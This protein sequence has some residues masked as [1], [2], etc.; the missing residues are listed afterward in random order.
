M[1]TENK[2]AS[3]R[4]RGTQKLRGG[5]LPTRMPA[6]F[7]STEV[8]NRLE[9]AIFNLLSS[10][11]EADRFW[12]KKQNCRVFNKK[13]YYSEARKSN[14]VFDVS[15]EVYL[16]GASTYSVLVL[17]ECKNYSS[18]PVPVDDV[19]E[20]YAKTQQVTG[21]NVKAIVATSTA[22]QTGALEF[23]KSKRIGLLRY[24]GSENFKWELYRSPSA[25]SRGAQPNVT[26]EITSGLT[27]P[28]FRSKVFDLFIQSPARATNS[29]WEF[30]DDVFAGAELSAAQVRKLANPKS[31][32]ANTVPFRE[33]SELETF[34]DSVLE[35][36]SYGTGAVS[37]EAICGDES[38]QSGLRVITGV[39]CSTEHGATPS[40][41]RI[42]FDLPEILIYAQP[43]PH[44]GRDRFTL[45]HEL[46]HYF[47]GHGEFMR[48]ETCDES[49]FVINRNSVHDG[50]DIARME[51]QANYFA[52]CLLMP[53]ANFIADFWRILNELDIR[54]LGYGALY[55]DDQPCNKENYRAVTGML[56]GR[57]NVSRA[58]VRI[59]LEGLGLLRKRQGAGG[60]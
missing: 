39:V 42:R 7:N 5:E 38:V 8:G 59:R 54:D 34:A 40:L 48:R 21:A 24:F 55:V 11:I 51:Y 29:L 46:G 13:P 49:D 26:Y 19:E 44:E 43:K 27:D 35:K 60:S 12:A 33:K 47:L 41:G 53:Q 57:Y 52:A 58:S 10:E 20:F 16:P 32:Q 18:E 3:A 17:V 30:F 50:S 36:V 31:R 28:D 22:F 25:G 37:L 4:S 6:S 45:A 1:G 56:R 14:I 2:S 9:E 23:S 15:I